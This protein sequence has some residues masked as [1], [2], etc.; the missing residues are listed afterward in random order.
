MTAVGVL[1]ALGLVAALAA[2]LRV[3]WVWQQRRNAR[4]EEHNT[5]TGRGDTP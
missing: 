3:G 5:I 2:V 4:P 1:S